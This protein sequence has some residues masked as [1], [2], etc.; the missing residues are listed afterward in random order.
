LPFELVDVRQAKVHRDCHVE[1]A[2]AYYSVPFRHIG[3]RL[4]VYLFERTVQIYDGLEL[5]VTHERATRKGQRVTRVEHY[6]ASKSIYLTRTRGYCLR[7]AYGIGAKCGEAVS[8]LLETRPLDNL[9]AVQGIIGLAEKYGESRLEAACCR[10]L[11]YGDPRY[12]RIRDILRSGLDL[13]PVEED[14]QL[15]LRLYE[16]ARSA[17]DFFGS[18]VSTC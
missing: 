7:R 4:E 5:V 6:P 8:V 13:Q 11:H 10:A 1:V 9:R 17:D 18:E 16:F 15:G 12:R 2:G 14:R 3:G